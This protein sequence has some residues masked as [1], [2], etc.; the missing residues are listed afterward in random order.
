MRDEE[1]NIT[2]EGTVAFLDNVVSNFKQWM[3][4]IS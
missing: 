2:E 4:Q 1:G 3:N